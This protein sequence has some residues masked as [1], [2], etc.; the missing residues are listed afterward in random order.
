MLLLGCKALEPDALLGVNQMRF[1]LLG[2]G[3]APIEI[4]VAH[5]DGIA[6]RLQF[7]TRVLADGFQQSKASDALAVGLLDG[8][9]RFVHQVAQEV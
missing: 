7:F 5:H 8:Q 3:D 9:E 1:A 2:P 6:C 4:T